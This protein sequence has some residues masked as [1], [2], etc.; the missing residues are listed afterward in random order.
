M[1]KDS[2]EETTAKIQKASD[3]VK[4]S[5]E[6]SKASHKEVTDFSFD[7]SPSASPVLKKKQE[8]AV[9]KETTAKNG[10]GQNI[11]NDFEEMGL[12]DALLRGVFAY[13]YEKPSVIQQRAIVPCVQGKDV[14][15][16]A[17]S[18]TGKTATFSIAMLQQLDIKSH[19]C[20]ALIL[21]PT[22]ELARQTHTVVLSL[23]DYLGVNA[24][25][26][27]GGER[28]VDMKKRLQSGVHVVV[29]TPGRVK[30]MIAEG[31][32]DTRHIKILVL[33]E[34][35]VMLSR[36]FEE[37]VR[38]IFFDLPN[39]ADLQAIAVTATLPPEVLKMTEKFMRNP[40]H[41]L[42]E[43]EEVPLEAIKQFYVDVELEEHKLDTICDIY[44]A[45]SVEQSMIFCNTRRKVEMVAYHMTS[46]DFTVSCIHGDQ[47]PEE[48]KTVMKEFRNGASRVLIATDVLQRG[49]DV[50]HV[51]MVCNFDLPNDKDSYI[52]RIGRCGRFGRKGIAISL[53]TRRDYQTIKT[54]E[55]YYSTQIDE[56]PQDF[57]QHLI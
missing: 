56:M 8:Q 39:K 38:D 29:G 4:I 28:V 23:G 30:H 45:L 10:E 15:A 17:Q 50:Q 31:A 22:R 32:L 47:T 13:G 46:Q 18:G 49:I 20:Q 34:V 57:A 27:V 3:Q 16:Q 36:G 25:L 51:S 21:S 55:T 41:I 43:N 54:L 19:H 5:E 7:W 53:I 12:S 37:Q 14:V 33:D 11:F 1:Q 42:V 6:Q 48:R 40:V 9:E 44:E 24:Y 26:V 35:D 52:H 2:K